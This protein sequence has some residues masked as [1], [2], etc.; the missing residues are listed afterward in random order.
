MKSPMLLLVAA[1]IAL[2]SVTLHGQATDQTA[3]KTADKAQSDEYLLLG[4]ANRGAGEPWVFINP[5]DHRNVI[6]VAMATLN[7]LPDGETPILP[8][9]TPA[10]T[11]LRIKELSTPDGSLTDI[12]VTH[13]GGA[14]WNFSE[15]DLR[16]I[17]GK[18]R[19]SDSFAGAGPDGNLYI[20][21]LAY[22]N[23]GAAD[24]EQGYAP[25][26]EAHY[27][28]GGSAIERSEDE[29]RTWSKPVWVHPA[30]SPSLYA[31]IIKPVFEQ[32]SPWDRPVFVADP[33]TGTIYVSGS[34][35][36]Y[37]V[38]PATVT[39]PPL[40]P[41]LPGMG[42]T[43]YPGRDVT[44]GHTFLR[45]SQ[46][47]GRT[48]GLI[49]PVDNDQY[50]GGWFAG[51]GG[52]SAAYGHLVVA[53]NASQIPAELHRSCP[54]TVLGTSENHGKTFDYQVLPPV[55][56]ELAAKPDPNPM[57]GMFGVMV[58]ADPTKQGRYAVARI[59]GKRILISITEDGGK[60][61]QDP[62]VAA[63][64]P[65]NATIGQHALKYSAKGDLGMIWKAMYADKSF[66]MWSAASKDGGRSFKTVPVSHA[67][68]PTYNPIRGNFMF[69]DDLS[70]LDIDSDYLYAVWGDN[71][72][73]FEGTWFGRVPLSAY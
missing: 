57:R 6:V 42:Y 59:E 37:T 7:R 24:Y 55:P 29:G 27:Y 38:D 71:R 43:G 10:A 66:D 8:R 47:E 52:F 20:G 36:A 15:D 17:E 48:W 44:R 54:C 56:P 39:R 1:I 19:C 64:V 65:E 23:R 61:W 73:G 63:E 12:A 11:Q 45:A 25:D 32:A 4:N 13:D 53:Y 28:H 67:V 41:S 35:L 26:G 21:C 16:K 3:D 51:V 49:Y 69:G 9:G 58:S 68:S 5:K 30:L 33:Q 60:T 2:T 62:V 40:N 50:P 46:D 14:T 22:L 18:N 34:G 70:S 72:S 31:P